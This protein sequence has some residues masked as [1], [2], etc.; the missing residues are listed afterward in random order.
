MDISNWRVNCSL[1]C[2][3]GPFSGMDAVKMAQKRFFPALAT[4]GI[5]CVFVSGLPA[6]GAGRQVVEKTRPAAA[7]RLS[8]IGRPTASGRLHL[9]I[10]LPLR[11]EADLNDLL[12]QL[13]D[14]KSPNFHRWQT[15]QQ[16]AE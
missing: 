16:L 2:P 7:A 8:P 12:G 9:A 4:L 15:P 14:P 11:N 1:T 10:G 13:Y 6:F 3:N 5:A